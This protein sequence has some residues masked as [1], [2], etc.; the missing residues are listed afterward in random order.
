MVS[1]LPG[2]FQIIWPTIGFSDMDS[3]MAY[4]RLMAVGLGLKSPLSFA[5][6][7]LFSSM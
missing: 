6:R 5:R 7:R 4:L 3:D 2:S 1:T